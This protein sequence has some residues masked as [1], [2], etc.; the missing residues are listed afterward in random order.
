MKQITLRLYN[1]YDRDLMALRRYYGIRFSGI[2]RNA[3]LRCVTGETFRIE[4]PEKIHQYINYD[5]PMTVIAIHCRPGLDDPWIDWLSRVRPR[6]RQTVIKSVIRYYYNYYPYEMFVMQPSDLEW[7]ENN[8][9]VRAFGRTDSADMDSTDS[10][11]GNAK[12]ND[13]K[14]ANR[15]ETEINIKPGT[16]AEAKPDIESKAVTKSSPAAIAANAD[17][18]KAEKNSGTYEPE[19]KKD[20]YDDAF[21]DAFAALMD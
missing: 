16:K 5:D 19:D 1:P 6:S 18:Q 10:H 21:D 9:S 4:I 11:T 2:I 17:S 7:M 8:K 14:P 3:L 13:T 15:I 12:T 20:A